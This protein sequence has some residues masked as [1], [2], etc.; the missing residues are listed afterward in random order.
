MSLKKI[1]A[2]ASGNVARRWAQVL[3]K[4]AQIA[5]KSSGNVVTVPIPK[6]FE[7]TGA[8][9]L[10]DSLLEMAVGG[11]SVVKSQGPKVVA[12]DDDGTEAQIKG[13]KTTSE[14]MALI[15]LTMA[16]D[17]GKDLALSVRELGACCGME[18]P[19]DMVPEGDERYVKG[20]RDG[21]RAAKGLEPEPARQRRPR[22]TNAQRQSADSATNGAT[23]S[24]H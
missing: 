5:L 19:D 16:Q 12:T 6:H 1:A 3:G 15:L 11:V 18:V 8:V 17:R 9:T 2:G 4:R 21:Y 13:D 7:E 10:R 23:T 20:T 22:Q 24:A 14:E